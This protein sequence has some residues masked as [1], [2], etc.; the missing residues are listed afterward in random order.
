MGK[1]IL[2]TNSA[3]VLTPILVYRE[4]SLDLLP[5]IPAAEK[6]HR[7]T[8]AHEQIAQPIAAT[9]AIGNPYRATEPTT[10]QPG[11][12]RATRSR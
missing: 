5:E 7:Q 10:R 1:R 8:T 9:R 3:K 6:R 4:G 11:R 2:L 12:R